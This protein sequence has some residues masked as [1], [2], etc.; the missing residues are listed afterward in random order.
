MAGVHVWALQYGYTALIVSAWSG[1]VEAMALLLDRGAN[2]EAKD[3]VS[4]SGASPACQPVGVVRGRDAAICSAR[5]GRPAARAAGPGARTGER[6]VR[7]G[8]AAGEGCG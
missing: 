7:C 6:R 2:L 3:T 8:C 5:R 4:T 1:H